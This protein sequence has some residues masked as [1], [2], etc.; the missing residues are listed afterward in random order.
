MQSINGSHITLVPKKD[1]ALKVLDYRSISLLNNSI[2]LI[3][4]L[5]ANRLQLV[6]PSLIQK[7]QHGF[8]KNRTIQDCL[9]WALEYLHICH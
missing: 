4:K 6:L 1:D 8:V 7:N 5:L 9:A 2:K 3:T